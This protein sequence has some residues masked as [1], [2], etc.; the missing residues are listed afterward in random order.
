MGCAAGSHRLG[1]ASS[2]SQ[3]GIPH[4]GNTREQNS[5]RQ[6][7]AENPGSLV[8]DRMACTDH[9]V[10]LRRFSATVLG[11]SDARSGHGQARPS[12]DAGRWRRDGT[13]ECDGAECTYYRRVRAMLAA[14]P[15]GDQLSLRPCLDL[16]SPPSPV[17][18]TLAAHDHRDERRGHSACESGRPSGGCR[19]ACYPA[20]RPGT[21]SRRNQLE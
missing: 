18:S 5:G 21:R 9:V 11:F 3:A 4:L 14:V 17:G 20:I 16:S 7:V 8:E 13:A 2:F 10:L 19:L 12:P 6:R 15:A 1:N